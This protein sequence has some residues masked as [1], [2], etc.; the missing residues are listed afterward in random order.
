M[1]E[2]R[3]NS[4]ACRADVFITRNSIVEICII[5]SLLA[6]YDKNL[7]M[8]DIY[9]D[10][11]DFYWSVSVVRLIETIVV[12]RFHQLYLLICIVHHFPFLLFSLKSPK[13]CCKVVKLLCSH[14]MVHFLISVELQSATVIHPYFAAVHQALLFRIKQPSFSLVRSDCCSPFSDWL[15]THKHHRAEQGASNVHAFWLLLNLESVWVLGLGWERL[16]VYFLKR[17]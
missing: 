15:R 13:L 16:V 1:R 9:A 14:I 6:F 2:I 8:P 10:I 7:L 12:S 5:T 4:W 17:R 11:V 3:F